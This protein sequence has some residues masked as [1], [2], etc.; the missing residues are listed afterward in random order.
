MLLVWDTLAFC[1]RCEQTLSRTSDEGA[2]DEPSVY[3]FGARTTVI[4][5]TILTHRPGRLSRGATGLDG[6]TSPASEYAPAIN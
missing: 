2:T 6:P 5:L 3:G 1:C 4:D